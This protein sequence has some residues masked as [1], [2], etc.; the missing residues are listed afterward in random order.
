MSRAARK[1]LDE[2]LVSRQ[3]VLVTGKGGVGKSVVAAAL[4]LR[5]QSLGLRPL[6]F[7]C[8]APARQSL[9]PKGR[10]ATDEVEEV[11]PGILAINQKSDDAIRDYAAAS[12]PSRAVADL[13]FENRIARMFLKAS[14][15]VSEMALVGR[16][17]I[18]AEKHGADGP[19]IVD[20]HATGHAI[21]LLRAPG[22]IMKV[23]RSGVLYDRAKQI[24]ELLQ[25]PVRTAFVT[26]ALPEE[27]PVTE[28]L[29]LHD[30]LKETKAPEGP[31]ILNGVF[32]DPAPEIGDDVVAH[33]DDASA[34]T[35]GR[36][37]AKNAAHD[38]AAL[39]A[40]ARR[41][42]REEKRLRDGLIASRGDPD[43]LTVPFFVVDGAASELVE[44]VA[45]V[46]A[47][48]SAESA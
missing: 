14:P 24:E 9:L 29:E 37:L 18:L 33:L 30:K 21:S 31:V 28:L 34:S 20:L 8:D 46:L 47:K 5:A 45:A 1:K 41:S 19:I 43:I 36:T 16:I 39:R 11:A 12:L 2:I 13:L 32:R 48:P 22:G 10:P 27:L 4:A 6:L 42:A 35:P 15:S 17:A 40:W 7:E 38:L 44:R 25:D 26:V 3:V 23:L